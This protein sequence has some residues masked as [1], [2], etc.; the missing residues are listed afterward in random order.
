MVCD[1]T[2]RATDVMS[3]GRLAMTK[4]AFFSPVTLQG[5]FISLQFRIFNSYIHA[6]DYLRNS[7]LDIRRVELAIS[8]KVERF[9]GNCATAPFMLVNKHQK[10]AQHTSVPP[11]LFHVPP[12]HFNIMR[13]P[14]QIFR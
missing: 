5:S 11:H 4:A 2:S 3:R 1:M 7:A 14:E 12:A 8:S 13:I 9:P 6:N 10:P